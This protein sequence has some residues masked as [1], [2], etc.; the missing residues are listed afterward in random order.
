MG[1]EHLAG[2]AVVGGGRG[3]KVSKAQG[4]GDTV[5]RVGP[6]RWRGVYFRGGQCDGGESIS[7]VANGVGAAFHWVGSVIAGHP[8][9]QNWYG[10]GCR[11]SFAC[12]HPTHSCP[13]V[14]DLYTKSQKVIQ[15]YIPF[16]KPYTI[17]FSDPS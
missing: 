17:F 11:G 3:A 12:T 15:P 8:A 5:V 7:E 9:R 14:R 16:F 6:M 10:V 2:G 13:E 4:S 1:V